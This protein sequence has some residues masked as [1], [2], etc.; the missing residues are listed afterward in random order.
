M[1]DCDKT[2][3]TNAIQHISNME[4]QIEKVLFD[5]SIAVDIPRLNKLISKQADKLTEILIGIK[6][7]IG[8]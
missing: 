1:P 5:S 6:S 4:V 8:R 2:T 7:N 3:I